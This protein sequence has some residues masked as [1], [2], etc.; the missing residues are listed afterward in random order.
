MK[1][2]IIINLGKSKALTEAAF[3][4]LATSVVKFPTASI[5]KSIILRSY[6]DKGYRAFLYISTNGSHQTAC[7]QKGNVHSY[8][9]DNPLQLDASK[10]G[11][12]RLAEELAGPAEIVINGIGQYE[13]VIDPQKKDGAKIGCTFVSKEKIKEVWDALQD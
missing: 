12:A 10:D 4:I 9:W 8:P 6:Q 5:T 7:D 1:H 3:A 13:A 2:P 11:L